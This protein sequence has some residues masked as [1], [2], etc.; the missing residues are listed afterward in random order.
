MVL[1]SYALQSPF[2]LAFNPRLTSITRLLARDGRL[3]LDFANATPH[4]EPGPDA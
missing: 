2:D 4:F 3:F 1:V